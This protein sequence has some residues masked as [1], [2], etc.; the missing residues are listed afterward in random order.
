[1]NQGGAFSHR[2]ELHVVVGLWHGFMQGAWH[3]ERPRGPSAER[4]RRSIESIGS[5][6]IGACDAFAAHMLRELGRMSSCGEIHVRAVATLNRIG[7]TTWRYKRMCMRTDSLVDY[8]LVSTC[9]QR[10]KPQGIN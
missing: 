2:D 1:M 4:L 3:G 10:E 5:K 9:M 7:A 6:S 8:F